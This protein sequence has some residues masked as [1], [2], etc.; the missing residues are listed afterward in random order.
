MDQFE[1]KIIFSCNIKLEN[2]KKKPIGLPNKWVNLNKSII[3]NNHKIKCILTGIKNNIIVID[4]DKE[5]G[6]S[7]Y[8]KYKHILEESYVETSYSDYKHVYYLYDNAFE[9]SYININNYSIDI[10]SNGKFCFMSDDNNGKEILQIPQIIKE[11]LLSKNN[12]SLDT[13]E[14][15]NNTIHS[16]E[17]IS[18]YEKDTNEDIEKIKELIKIIPKNYSDNRDS[19]IKIGIC[20]KDLIYDDDIAFDIWQDF[21]KLSEKYNIKNCKN[22]WKTFNKNN[23]FTIKSLFH[24]AK[25]NKKEFNKWCKKYNTKSNEPIINKDNVLKLNKFDLDDNYNFSTFNNYIFNNIFN[26]IDEAIEY[27][28]KNLYKCCVRIND[29]MITKQVIDEFNNIH[30]IE[31]FNRIWRTESLIKYYDNDKIFKIPLKDIL[32]DYPYLINTFEK[33]NNEFITKDTIINENHFYI[34]EDY[35][36]KYINDINNDDVEKIQPL[37]DMIKKVYCNNN[38]ELYNLLM[39]LFSFWVCNPNEKSGKCL[40]L[41]GKQGCG[42]STI[43]DFF[44]EFIFGKKICMFLKGFKELLADKNGH[45]SGK[46][47]V[48]L[49]EVRSKKGDYY[50]NYD[51]LKTLIS[52][53]VIQIR[54][55]FKETKNEKSSMEL[56]ITTNNPNCCPIEENDRKYIV[57]NV[58]DVY[59]QKDKEF[60]IPFRKQIF[61]QEVG[62]IFYSYLYNMNTTLDKWRSIDFASL[63]TELKNDLHNLN[64]NSIELFLNDIKESIKELNLENNTLMPCIEYYNNKNEYINYDCTID[65]N[66]NI[67]FQASKIYAGYVSYCY[68]NG[69]NAVSNKYFGFDLKNKFN[70][71]C[72]KKKLAN[73]YCIKLE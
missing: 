10:L 12:E 3:K 9:Q 1:D 25:E 37:L 41:T 21:S 6:M 51:D 61:N 64:K 2:N 5:L 55:L 15:D 70:I 52:D 69:E 35:K 38:E 17:D 46:K 57:L 14:E 50:T 73:Y 23:K 44:S 60:W 27:I 19:W 54:G 31:P 36:A 24:Y 7:Y 29:Y 58:S 34:T 28:E 53:S 68:H 33:I 13:E 22:T 30:S 32:Q 45:L 71:E 43:I 8:N 65:N 39:S 56:V 48:N 67:L 66:K 49:N 47:F 72:K 11:F 59:M 18:D 16:D 42:K 4:F 40:I 63:N 62:N 26:N 20:T